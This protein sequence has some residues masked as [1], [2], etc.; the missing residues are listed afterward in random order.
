MQQC[1]ARTWR[2]LRGI[3][4]CRASVELRG[5]PGRGLRRCGGARAARAKGRAQVWRCERGQG[6]SRPRR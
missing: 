4:A 3:A 1:T 2:R 5:R 6:G